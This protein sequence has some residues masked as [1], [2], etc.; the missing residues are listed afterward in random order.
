MQG[1]II[2]TFSLVIKE[3]KASLW[4]VTGKNRGET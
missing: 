1:A 2:K 3:Q 4:L